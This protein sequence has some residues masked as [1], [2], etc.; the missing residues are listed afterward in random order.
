MS[1]VYHHFVVTTDRRDVLL[2]FLREKGIGCG[3]YY[4]RSDSFAACVCAFWEKVG[5]FPVAEADVQRILSLPIFP[6]LRDEEVEEVIAAV[7]DG[8]SHAHEDSLF[9]SHLNTKL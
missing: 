2:N 6:Q 3:V 8:V 5:D 4:P 7:R 9:C 1:H